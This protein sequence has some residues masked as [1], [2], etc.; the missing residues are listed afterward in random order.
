MPADLR[1]HAFCDVLVELEQ[2]AGR[3]RR[4]G[5][6]VRIYLVDAAFVDGAVGWP[7]LV[8]DAMARWKSEGSLVEMFRLHGPL[9][10]ALAR[11]AGL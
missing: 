9:M 5:T 7:Q 2:L 8:R 1:H 3:A 6:S 11:F 10:R 4:G